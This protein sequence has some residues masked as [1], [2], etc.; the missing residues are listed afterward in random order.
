MGELSRRGIMLS[1]LA[2]TAASSLGVSEAM[3]KPRFGKPKK[4]GQTRAIFGE[5]ALWSPRDQGVWWVDLHGHGLGFTKPD[6]ATRYYKTPGF[7]NGSPRALAIRAQ[8]GLLLAID[9]QLM[10]LDPDAT[11]N[12][13]KKLDIN[14]PVSPSHMFNDSVVDAKGRFIV[15]TVLPGRGNDFQAKIFQIDGKGVVKVLVEGLCTCNGLAFSP[16][17]KTIYYCDTAKEVLKVWKAPYD[18]ETG[19]IGKSELFIDYKT[20]SGRP[21]G[22]AVD[23]EGYY[24]SAAIESPHIFRFSPE[25][26]LDITLKLPVDTPTRPTFGGKDLK[27]LFVTTAGL[28]TGDWEDGLKGSLFAIQTPFTGLVPFMAAL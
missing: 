5:S 26:K 14:V 18:V 28:R 3:A 27:T 4:V 15:G 7:P 22:A 1:G 16:D 12:R 10:T 13:F 11:S 2:L 17:N 9:N 8:G 6:G 24:W 19:Q 25:G 20:L 21:D 23:T